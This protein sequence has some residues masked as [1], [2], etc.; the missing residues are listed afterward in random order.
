MKL[1]GIARWA[2]VLT[3]CQAT[4]AEAPAQVSLTSGSILGT[5]RDAS[6]AVAPGAEVAARHV[7]TGLVR[8]A[9]ANE[10]G[11][12][13]IPQ[14]PVGAYRVSAALAGFKTAVV[15]RLVLEVNQR[16][17][18]DFVL[19]V[20]AVSDHI[21]VTADA[22]LLETDTSARGEVIDSHQVEELP[23][24]GRNFLQLALLIPGTV[25]GEG[26]RQ[27]DRTG[28]AVS[29]NGLRTA[30]NSYSVDGVDSN[31]NLN[32]FFTLRPNVDAIQE[33]KVFT[34]LY[35]AEFGRTAGAAVNVVTRSG[36]NR[37]HG[38]LFDFHRNAALNARNF[39]NTGERKEPF[40]YNQFGGTFGFPVVR[41]RTFGFVE[42]QG[43]RSRRGDLKRG[44]VPT[45]KMRRGDFSGISRTIRDPLAGSAFAGNVIPAARLDPV[46]QKVLEFVPLPTLAANPGGIN[47]SAFQ[48]IVEDRD[49]F[50]IRLD[51][52]FSSADSVFVRFSSW[53][54]HRVLPGVFPTPAIGDSAL[55]TSGE[56]SREA[57]RNAAVSYTRTLDRRTLN[58]FRVGYNRN[59]VD[60][61]SLYGDHNWA[62][63][64]GIA[65]PANTPRESLFPR[66][67]VSGWTT[68]GAAGF[69]PNLRVVENLQL[70]D[71][72]SL[73]RGNHT[74]KM[75][76]DARHI[77]LDGFFPPNLAGNFGVSGRFSGDAMA[78]FILGYPDTA[79]VTKVED[80]VRD[81]TIWYAAFL[82]DD[83]N[84]LSR[85]TLNLGL[86]WDLLRPPEEIRDRKAVFDPALGRLIP[87]GTEGIPRAGYSTDWNNLGPRFGFAFRARRWMVVRGGYGLFHS[88]QTLNTQNNL[89]RNPPWQVNLTATSNPQ[90]PTLDFVRT[91]SGG[92]EQLFPTANGVSRN[93]R[94]AYTQ[95]FTIA[96]QYLPARNLMIEAAYVGTR[97]VALP[98]DPNI[99]QPTAGSGT[100]QPRRP[101]P[102]V[103]STIL[104]L[105]PIG[106]SVYH[107]MQLKAES[108]LA[109]GLGYRIGYT[110]SKAIS[111]SEEFSSGFQNIYN[112]RYDRGRGNLDAR[113]RFTSNFSYALPFG[114]GHRLGASWNGIVDAL[115]GGWQAV[116]IVTLRSGFPFTPTVP[117]DPANV[118][119]SNR[120]NRLAAG[121]LD[122]PTLARWYDPAAF[123]IPERFT[124]GTSGRNILDGPGLRRAD[125]SIHKNF[126]VR[127]G[128][129]LQ[130]RAEMFNMTNTPK[131]QNPVTN[132][133]V[134]SAGQITGATGAREIQLAL[135]YSF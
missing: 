75:G 119:G 121:R 52:R 74:M 115:L 18:V 90:Q 24:N 85:L 44:F 32:N 66:I 102:D 56:E 98:V 19:E 79:A 93:W 40:V 23:L 5:V 46:A 109:R 116:G 69:L 60:R 106:N 58:E 27:E 3:V 126:R 62:G 125:F 54:Q 38:S 41:D 61:F 131:F 57:V 117:G 7:E 43:L 64:L 101:F 9:I 37:Y 71:T 15:D 21:Q 22:A 68:Y 39:F 82:Q 30:E 42:Y 72:F 94:D 107:S 26:S 6:G 53:N 111:D 100:I 123:A 103:Y 118:G 67:A 47:Y 96:T 91:L 29:V 63:E 99:N 112:R 92:N 17:R 132:V 11:N 31:D 16:A 95:H 114:A 36:T 113:H 78:D 81:R 25:E 12:Y 127:E 73:V 28:A 65:G 84:A 133:T 134:Q 1:T 129:R 77:R 70:A 45:E 4:G 83:W 135:K 10:S 2:L 51:H 50:S 122:N 120:P 48:K 80:Y 55:S 108:R 105:L 124:F 35:D 87:V 97:G 13:S 33:F 14:L 88:S 130:F 20:G 89:G 86:R 76:L 128:H 110:L 34:N 8:R 49:Q 104:I 59:H